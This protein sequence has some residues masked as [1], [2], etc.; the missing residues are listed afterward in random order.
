ML[1]NRST[2]GFGLVNQQQLY[3]RLTHGRRGIAT[4]HLSRFANSVYRESKGR[5]PS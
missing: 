2:G 1:R 5:K 3:A 4:H